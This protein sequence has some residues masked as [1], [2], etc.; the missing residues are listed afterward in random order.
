M[1]QLTGRQ[2]DPDDYQVFDRRT[3]IFAVESF[4][5]ATPPESSAESHATSDSSEIDGLSRLALDKQPGRFA[6]LELVLDNEQGQDDGSTA[7]ARILI[8]RNQ[9]KPIDWAR[10]ERG[11]KGLRVR[12]TLVGVRSRGGSGELGEKTWFCAKIKGVD[13]GFD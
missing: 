3:G 5:Q 4:T 2:I 13:P 9:D 8:D 7:K 1:Q 10:L 6:M 12:G 11:A